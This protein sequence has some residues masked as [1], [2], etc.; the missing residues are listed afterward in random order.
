M[1]KRQYLASAEEDTPATRAQELGYKTVFT[2]GEDVYKRQAL[3]I[4]GRCGYLPHLRPTEMCIIDSLGTCSSGIF[5]RGGEIAV[6]GD[7]H[8]DGAS[9]VVVTACADRSVSSVQPLSLIHI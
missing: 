8:G 9:S 6:V 1:Y 5:F 7:A 2:A 3:Q 4:G